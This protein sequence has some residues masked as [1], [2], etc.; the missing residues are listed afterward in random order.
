MRKDPPP[1]VYDYRAVR[2]NERAPWHLTYDVNGQPSRRTACSVS[3]LAWAER[4]VGPIEQVTC[5]TC[6]TSRYWTRAND[7]GIPS[8]E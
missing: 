6:R 4:Q 7:K 1:P 5:R 3:G 2:Y 8:S